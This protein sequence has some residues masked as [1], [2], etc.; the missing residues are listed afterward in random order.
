VIQRLSLRS[1]FVLFALLCLI[2]LLSVIY[3]VVQE[4]LE[5][6]REKTIETEVA[7][8]EV[9]AANV[10][11]ALDEHINVLIDI[12][13][14]DAV[15]TLN[16]DTAQSTVSQY[17][18]ARPGLYGIMLIGAED[19]SVIVSSGNL[20][21]ALL[22]PQ[23]QAD[24]DSAFTGGEP[25]ITGLIPNPATEGTNMVGLIVPVRADPAE[26]EAGVPV[27]VLVGFLNVDRLGRSFSSAFTIAQTDTLAAV[28]DGEQVIIS[29]ANTDQSNE[30]LINDLAAP[31]A[32]A[33]TGVRSNLTYS[34]GGTQRVAVFAPVEYSGA[35]WAVVVSNPAPSV[36]GDS[37]DFVRQ[38]LLALALAVALTLL[39]ATLFGELLSRAIRRLTGQAAAI[40]QGDY[41][42]SVDVGGPGE[43]AGLSEAV[44]D[45]ADRL[46]TQVRDLDSARIDV[47]QHAERLRD[48]LRRTVRLQ[49]DERRRIA[50][51]IHDAVSPLIT[52]A[53]YQTRALELGVS[54]NGAEPALADQEEN[55]ASISGL[56]ERAMDELHSVIFALRPPD[57]D[58][59]GV[60]AA[61]ERYVQ[62]IERNGLPCQFSVEGDPRRLSPEAR[63]AI[64]RIVQE[65]LHNALRH[66][67]ADAA[68]VRME[69]FEESLRVSIRDNGSGFDPETAS[70]STSLGLLS[71]RERASSIGATFTI[72]SQPGD[73]TLVLIERPSVPAVSLEG[74][75]AEAPNGNGHANGNGSSH[76]SAAGASN[77]DISTPRR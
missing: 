18:R 67:R 11:L 2:P 35:E 52:G 32:A 61:I 28:V 72:V 55:L 12:A 13:S 47:A 15:R 26:A 9:I 51:D 43:I 22:L 10:T 40:A 7:I 70:N 1:R 21:P 23:I 8:A 49:E 17:L 5:E 25:I 4:S 24:I 68:E 76:H 71:M 30:A 41:S 63:L 27:G 57:L 16:A 74:V 62:Q 77:G 56:L 20:D 36:T 66:A 19:R 29:Q 75:D 46:T 33:V 39:L 44:G 59:L 31:I 42:K 60:E 48:L 37:R 58:D 14:T 64:Y 6:S 34:S 73:G 38:A 54:S 69:W 50:G 53:L 3:Y 45:M 65:A